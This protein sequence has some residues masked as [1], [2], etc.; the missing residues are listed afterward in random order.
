MLG[1]IDAHIEESSSLLMDEDLDQALAHMLAG[2]KK[3]NVSRVG[4]LNKI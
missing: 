4:N 3:L 1:E 2:L